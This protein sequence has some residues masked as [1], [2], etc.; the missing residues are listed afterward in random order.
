LTLIKENH[1][2]NEDDDITEHMIPTT[3]NKE[4]GFLSDSNMHIF[5]KSLS[6]ILLEST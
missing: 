6:D 5:K 2:L 4:T 3:F 1:G